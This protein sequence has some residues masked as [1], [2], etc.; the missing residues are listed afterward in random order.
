MASIIR[1]VQQAALTTGGPTQAFT[2]SAFSAAQA[3]KA[4]LFFFAPSQ[5]GANE[6]HARFSIGF[7][8]GTSHRCVSVLARDNQGI[9]SDTKRNAFTAK[10]LSN[11]DIAGTGLDGEMAFSSIQSD[12]IVGTWS[13]A[14]PGTAWPV[15][16]LLFGGSDC[17][18]YV[19]ECVGSTSDGGATVVDATTDPLL[20]FPFD[21]L[22]LI[23]RS[24]PFDGSSSSHAYLSIGVVA[25]DGTS[26]LQGCL[27]FS[28][29]SQRLSDVVGAML[30][31]NRCYRFQS[32]GPVADDALEC[33]ARASDGFTL[34]KRGTSALA[35]EIGFLALKLG[36]VQGI[37]LFSRDT[38]TSTGSDAWTSSGH[39]AQFLFGLFSSAT[40]FN[41]MASGASDG[42]A[43]IGAAAGDSGAHDEFCA[44]IIADDGA[45]TSNTKSITDAIFHNLPIQT[46]ADGTAADLTSIQ[47]NGA[48]L[49]YS[50]AALGTARKQLILSV[51]RPNVLAQAVSSAG[52]VDKAAPSL[53]TSGTAHA[54]RASG[55]PGAVGRAAGATAH[56]GRAKSGPGALERAVAKSAHGGRSRT[57]PAGGS[58]ASGSAVHAGRARDAG[59]AQERAAGVGAH[60]GVA[61]KASKGAERAVGAASHAARASA[62][63]G[64]RGAGAPTKQ[65]F[66]VAF[67]RAQGAPGALAKAQASTTHGG[68]AARSGGAQARGQGASVK[69]ARGRSAQGAADLAPGK[70][71]HVARASADAGAS[72]RAPGVK[73][74]GGRALGD[75][76]AGARGGAR[77]VASHA[78]RGRTAAGA[79]LSASGKATQRAR[80]RSVSGVASRVALRESE[81]LGFYA[82]T[83][84][85]VRAHLLSAASGL[86]I[87]HENLRFTEPNGS[88]ARASIDFSEIEDVEYGSGKVSY[89]VPGTL[90]VE[91]RVPLREGK[92][93]LL[94]LAGGLSDGLQLREVSGV[95][96]AAASMGPAKDSGDDEFLARLSI[97]FRAW[98][99]SYS[100]V[101]GEAPADD[102]YEGAERAVRSRFASELPDVAVS[103]DNLPPSTG[104]SWIRLAVNEQ[105][106]LDAGGVRRTVGVMEA[107]VHVPLH[108]G[109]KAALILAD[110]V[111][112]AF[113]TVDVGGVVFSIPYLSR[114]K[115]AAGQWVIPVFCPWSCDHA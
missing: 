95:V 1:G 115:R 51:G 41:T 52:S 71:S 54:G 56:A 29:E 82:R 43:G 76:Q 31:D 21:L 106:G 65:T 73:A 70:A 72:S 85:S 22:F 90:E 33:T 63:G 79:A 58:R 110:R 53:V 27:S 99:S 97:P 42:I 107:A 108:T 57:A 94:A 98:D 5:L 30:D 112:E 3:V 80:A 81:I 49:N 78:G 102:D 36:G 100:R 59:G 83:S 67:G 114:G 25:W 75:P 89:L 62:A 91:L 24:G 109:T 19:G 69:R 45:G 55:A 44:T 77:G 35:P 93:A 32:Q 103:Y 7:T 84:R 20:G 104:L 16:C 74:A 11:Y 101:A 17:L 39:A 18:A 48:T 38:L 50:K 34:T 10:L 111:V 6:D 66:G 96:Y 40:A 88:W 113:R 4:G 68:R 60:R 23:S 28:S 15:N 46:G 26:I 47:H 2:H 64:E 87:Q 92:S 13:G 12:G 61:R 86:Q 9:Q 14:F 37:K 8:D 105:E